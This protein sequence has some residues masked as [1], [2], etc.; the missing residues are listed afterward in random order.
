MKLTLHTFTLTISLLI[1][2]STHSQQTAIIDNNMFFTDNSVR[3]VLINQLTSE[4][5]EQTTTGFDKILTDDE[6]N[7]TET[8][9]NFQNGQAYKTIKTSTSQEYT[10]YFT[11]L[12]IIHIQVNENL[13][14]KD[15][16]VA[17]FTM[18]ESNQTFH[19][20]LMGIRHRGASSL[21]FP[22]KS[23]RIEFWEDSSGTVNKDMQFLDMR[24]DDDWNLQSLI[25]E[26]LRINSK[27]NYKLWTQIDTLYYSDLEPEASNSLKMR[28]T[29]VFIN[30]VYQGVYSLSE[31]LDRK[32]LKL[33]KFKNGKI[34]GEMY[35]GINWTSTTRFE[36][37]PTIQVTP[38]WEGWRLRHPDPVDEIIDWTN[39]H[40]L[41]SFVAY[42]SDDYFFEHVEEK[43]HIDNLINHFI[44]INT[45]RNYD[46]LGNNLHVA[47]YK[48]GEPYLFIP[49][50]LDHSWGLDHKGVYLPNIAGINAK[51]LTFERLLDDCSKG[52]FNERLSERWFTLRA[53]NIISHTN[54]MNL[55]TDD[56]NY[57]EENGVYIREEAKWGHLT[58]PAN[59]LDYEQ[60]DKIDNWLSVRLAYLDDYYDNLCS[61]IDEEEEPEEED[62]LSVND[63]NNSTLIT[64]YPNPTSGIINIKI[65]SENEYAIYNALGEVIINGRLSSGVNQVDLQSYSNGIYFIK[66]GTHE[67][68]KVILR[69]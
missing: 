59:Q 12:P 21:S 55:L 8:I 11:E 41:I 39:F 5:N 2:L 36:E 33:K 66:I 22:K 49:W 7:F 9:H 68:K 13:N 53:N 50:D 26:P 42:S 40:E 6:Y 32:Q 1:H 29:E 19:S 45:M 48:Q 65:A 52:G 46:A 10:F 30:G 23:F 14:A 61:G 64:V 31:R 54:I 51:N 37:A 67:M 4:I 18:S 69:N 43:F 56:Y 3:I 25:N 58:H 57:L 28:F 34:K 35:K 62:N 38:E 60:L 24:K 27:A 63:I 15:Y 20:E 47:R 16:K 17:R 44:F